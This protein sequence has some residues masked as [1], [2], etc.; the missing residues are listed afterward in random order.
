M[1]T[2]A[3]GQRSFGGNHRFLAPNRLF[4]EGGSAQ[5]PT[6]A[7]AVDAI[8]FEAAR[9]LHFSA[10]PTLLRY[11]YAVTYAESPELYVKL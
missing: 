11:A 9:P 4:V 6:N 10:H 2:R 7:I 5:V 8:A 1:L 3:A